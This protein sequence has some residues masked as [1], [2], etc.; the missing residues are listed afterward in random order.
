MRP[1]CETC[2]ERE[3]EEMGRVWCGCA[4]CAVCFARYRYDGSD[5]PDGERCDACYEAHEAERAAS[6]EAAADAY[7]GAGE[8][9]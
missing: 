4:A 1:I 6:G 7:A 3:Y 2:G 5:D 9:E 8:D